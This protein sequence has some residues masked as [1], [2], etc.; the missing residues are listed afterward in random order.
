MDREHEY[1][2]T[3]DDTALGG[4]LGLACGDALGR[5]IEF[6]RADEIAA[7]YGEVT[8][9]TVEDRLTTLGEAARTMVGELRV[10]YK[11]L[12]RVAVRHPDIDYERWRAI[13]TK[14][15]GR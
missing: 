15:G 9:T 8:D 4:L 1:T 2:V 14:S 10:M 6:R 5:S 7:Q 3:E 11:S 12:R 13:A